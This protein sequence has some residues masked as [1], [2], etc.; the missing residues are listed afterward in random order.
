M[1]RDAIRLV[2]FRSLGASLPWASNWH[3]LFGLMLVDL[4]GIGRYWH[5][6][7]AF[8]CQRCGVGSVVAALTLTMLLRVVLVPFQPENWSFRSILSFVTMTAPIALLHAL[9]IQRW[10]QSPLAFD[11]EAWVIVVVATWRL[12][13]L[14]VYLRTHTG[15]QPFAASMAT[16]LMAELVLVFLAACD[17]E[18]S[19][20]VIGVKVTP[21]YGL[22]GVARL[23]VDYAR[24][25]ALM[26]V[27]LTGI[28][29]LY[30]LVRAWWIS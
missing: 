12:L 4:V 16:A 15:L 24:F 6:A 10:V 11:V 13:L 28:G 19:C 5:Q 7:D 17:L 29:Y 18:N 2:T 23:L 25:W 30:L 26:L 20:S 14:R 9:P 1:T 21:Y 3:L 22:F 8:I 27:P